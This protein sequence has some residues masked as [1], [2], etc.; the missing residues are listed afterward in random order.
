MKTLLYEILQLTWGL[1]QSVLGLIYLAK[2]GHGKEH[3]RFHG[4]YVS[5]WD[6]SGGIS[7]GMFIFI[8][9][10]LMNAGEPYAYLTHE[11]GHSIQSLLLGPLYIPVIGIPS[12]SWAAKYT[13]EKLLDGISYFSVFPENHANI[14]GT[15][16][17]GIKVPEH[18]PMSILED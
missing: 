11:Y 17:T 13:K 9:D 7:L 5:K 15:M 4:A 10:K 3:F 8:G 6:H 14:L 2:Y 18:I 1:P 12:N 16:V